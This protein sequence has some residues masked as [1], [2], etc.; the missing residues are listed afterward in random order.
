MSSE[1]AGTAGAQESAQ[2][3]NTES[4]GSVE[5]L[6]PDDHNAERSSSGGRNHTPQSARGRGSSD[7]GW[8]RGRSSARGWL[9][10]RTGSGL[11]NRGWRGGSRSRAGTQESSEMSNSVD[12]FLREYTEAIRNGMG[13]HD[14]AE[15]LMSHLD[16]RGVVALF[17]QMANT[18]LEIEAWELFGWMRQNMPASCDTFLYTAMI[19]LCAANNADGVELARQLC[20]EMLERGIERNV[21]TYSALMNVLIKAGRLQDALNVY[22][23]DMQKSNVQPNLV[24][25]N[26]LIDCY[27]KTGQWGEALQVLEEMRN[28][29]I[30]P[31]TRTFNT[32][33]IACNTNNQW[34]AC[35]QI[36]NK[37]LQAGVEA[38]TTTF[39]AL[40]SAYSKGGRIDQVF[41]VF[42]EMVSCGC[43]RTVITYSSL[44]SACEKA[45]RWEL[46]L[47]M[48]ARMYQ[49]GCRPN[50]ITFNSLIS[51][52]AQGSQWQR[53]VEL[54]EKMQRE[55]CHPDVVT[56]TGLISACER[57]G[58]WKRAIKFYDRMRQV[59]CRPDHI[60]YTTLVEGLWSVGLPLAQQQ[61]VKLYR[62]ACA[63]GF[64]KPLPVVPTM[65]SISAA[66][67]AV[68]VNSGRA[69]LE[70]HQ[71]LPLRQQ[72]EAP[73]FTRSSLGTADEESGS[74][75]VMQSDEARTS[76]ETMVESSGRGSGRSSDNRSSFG[77]G[78]IYQSAHVPLLSRQFS[79]LSSSPSLYALS[80]DAS[81][82]NPVQL[83]RL[84]SGTLSN[85]SSSMTGPSNSRPHKLSVIVDL[86]NDEEQ[87]VGGGI[88]GVD[89]QRQVEVRGGG[90][91]E[92]TLPGQLDS[93]LSVVAMLCWL[94]DLQDSWIDLLL[95]QGVPPSLHPGSSTTGVPAE[96]SGIQVLLNVARYMNATTTGGHLAF[97]QLASLVPAG[98]TNAPT[99]A[100]HAW[101]SYHGAPFRQLIAS[102]AG[103]QQ[104]QQ[105]AAGTPGG[106]SPPGSPVPQMLSS[107][108]GTAGL[109]PLQASGQLLY[110]W[111]MTD[112]IIGIL[113]SFEVSVPTAAAY[114]GHVSGPMPASSSSRLA[115]VSGPVQVGGPGGSSKPPHHP[116][117]KSMLRHENSISRIPSTNVAAAAAAAA[118]TAAAA[119]GSVGHLYPPPPPSPPSPTRIMS[120]PMAQR[121]SSRGRLPLPAGLLGSTGSSR[122]YIM[123]QDQQQQAE[124]HARDEVL[125]DSCRSIFY[126]VVMFEQTHR[127]DM[128]AMGPLYIAV[129]MKEL[130]PAVMKAGYA[131]GLPE[132]IP[133]DSLL[134]LD[135]A[136]ST[137]LTFSDRDLPLAIH[138]ALFICTRQASMDLLPL[139][140]RPKDFRFAA[141]T[142]CPLTEL[143]RMEAVL[144]ASLAQDTAAIS[145][146]HSLLLYMSRLEQWDPQNPQQLLLQQQGLPAPALPSGPGA[147]AGMQQ[148]APA[149]GAGLPL[150]RSQ[151]AAEG[152]SWPP[153]LNS[154][155]SLRISPLPPLMSYWNTG[156][157]DPMLLFREVV[158]EPE[159]M[160]YRPSVVAAA[161]L[162]ASRTA[163]GLVP[164][165]PS[166]LLLLTGYDETN[167]PEFLAASSAAMRIM[168]QAQVYPKRVDQPVVN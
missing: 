128:A 37:M 114:S 138:A 112:E 79:G 164:S 55:G 124:A 120:L 135:R 26:T 75:G 106:A 126:L 143:Y 9:L 8:K 97:K 11:G 107:H 23:I 160:N 108:T 119:A 83:Q 165:W 109:R 118:V 155:G 70:G 104:Q 142:G 154:L 78:G 61:A 69:E 161:V 86:Q 15:P 19:S 66:A 96:V 38:N 52:C 25:Y 80:V 103:Q 48:F 51:A 65:H 159:F 85:T 4:E 62:T 156:L 36:H 77:V 137:P 144:R 150:F 151:Y 35:L 147:V 131:L 54:F 18:G 43:E 14:A 63:E 12:G 98:S 130:L 22:C 101:L 125:E 157:A 5:A 100:V 71:S 47:Q 49:E 13:I 50:T 58:Q 91:L 30:R 116:S 158:F 76:F 60:V 21:H 129:R 141:I 145:S 105:V 82:T 42:E 31:V 27:G 94:C 134:L 166:C 90:V 139:R 127:L 95:L 87:G 34:Q 72:G 33:M 81:A 149:S 67:T 132:Q 73:A 110:H 162:Y 44:I 10:S 74:V 40:I 59:G 45:G 41:E 88:V 2:L 111:L 20:R 146:L 64:L 152:A 148:V 115:P 136:M 32:L 68:A 3:P 29:G 123:E 121:R 1:Y 17:K 53:A 24:T 92:V 99:S 16:S 102:G 93:G 39:N 113:S 140:K 28:Q 122:F 117:S 7:P 89:E 46:A 56:Y 6:A 133:H 168:R 167:N 84:S 153:P 163:C 57:G